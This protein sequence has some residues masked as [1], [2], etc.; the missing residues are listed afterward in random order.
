MVDN[1]MT[2]DNV[3]RRRLLQGVGAGVAA[4]ALAGQAAAQDDA[5][6]I[7]G[8]R[9]SSDFDVAKKRANGVR[10]ELDFGSIGKA[11]SGR[12]SE[13]AIEALENNPNVR[14]AEKNG[15]MH[16]LEQTT[17]YGI[18]KVDA[19]VA[20]DDGETGEGA[21]IAIIDTGIDPE[22]ETLAENLGEGW[23]A[24]DA[25]CDADCG[26]GGP[27]GGGNAIEECLEVWDDDNDHG[28]H[29]AGTAAAADNGEGVL[30]VAPDA[31]MHAVKVL[32]CSGG[33][34]WDGVAAGIEWA[35]DQD[36]ID[37]LS[38]SLGGD[39]SDVVYDAV[40]Y[41]DQ[42]GKVQVAAAGNDG[43]C[44]DCVG[45]PAAHDEVIAVSATDENDDLADFSSTGPEVELAAPGVDTLSTIPRDDYA[46]FSGTSMACPHVS[47]AAATLIAAGY[48][49]SEVRQVLK[50]GAE[51]IGLDD[52]EQG[53]G[54][55]NVANSLGIEVDD[56]DDGDDDD[57]DDG[58]DDDG[59]DGD[60]GDNAP[61]I[62]QFD[63]STRSSGPWSRADVDW[64]V[65]D[66]DGDLASVT[67]E[68]LDGSSVLDSDSS[69]V[70]GSSASGEHEVRTRDNPDGVRLTVVDEAGNETSETQDY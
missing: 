49:R 6:Y 5:E 60:T 17:P 22:H 45:Y 57:G 3:S 65:S 23:A 43:E 4:T 32:D 30:G 16:A 64:A 1:N 55:L 19:D 35:A 38:M 37:V 7:I 18:E 34:S 61:V 13:Q 39:E 56:G 52:N 47:G 69:G 59:D 67:T 15:R 20:I 26:G 51:D 36:Q 8:L 33:G 54:R 63:V 44:T 70:S 40:Q 10:F 31:T 9:A 24:D 25:E 27:F 68:L 2:R 46:E 42:Q 41:A 14:Y 62:D 28:S 29:C 48:D 50:D 11:V 66:E 58:D 53:A 21:N 12:F